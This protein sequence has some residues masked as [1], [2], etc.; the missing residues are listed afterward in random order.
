MAI[1]TAVQFVMGASP[2]SSVSPR[3][4]CNS[5]ANLPGLS[6]PSAIA[7]GPGN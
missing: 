6:P 3:S 7:Q 1:A 2:S 5:A 4:R